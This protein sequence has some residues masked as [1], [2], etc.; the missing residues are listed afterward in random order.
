MVSLP[1]SIIFKVFSICQRFWP[2]VLYIANILF[3]FIRLLLLFF[4]TSFTVLF[5]HAFLNVVIA[6]I[7]HSFIASG[8]E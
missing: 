2:S 8:F 7:N 4:F 5:C 3:L 6:C 1:F